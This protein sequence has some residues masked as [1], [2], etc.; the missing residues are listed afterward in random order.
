MEIREGLHEQMCLVFL[1]LQGNVKQC[2]SVYE[3]TNLMHTM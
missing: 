1:R 3:K 2:L